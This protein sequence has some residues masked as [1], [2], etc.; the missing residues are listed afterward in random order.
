M[1]EHI[2]QYLIRLV[3]AHEQLAV[4]ALRLADSFDDI[5][6]HLEESQNDE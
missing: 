3:K 6:D 2:E 5:V 1:D 4:A